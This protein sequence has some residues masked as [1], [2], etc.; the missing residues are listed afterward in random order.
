MKF[1]RM[2]SRIAIERT[3]TTTNAYGERTNTWGTLATVWADVIYRD[4][5]GSETI[6][7]AQVLSKQPVHFLI[8]YSTTVADVSPKDRVSYNS[9]LYNIEAVQEVGRNDGLRLT[10]T[11]RE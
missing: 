8:R 4:G 11:I 9:K 2:D 10:C 7:S 1:G 3:T 6:Q 5:S